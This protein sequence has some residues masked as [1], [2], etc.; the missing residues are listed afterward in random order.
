MHRRNMLWGTF[1]ALGAVIA[2]A[3]AQATS[4]TNAGGRLKVIH[5]LSGLDQVAFVLGNIQN[6]LDGVGGP[7]RVTIALVVH[8][9]AFGIFHASGAM[10]KVGRVVDHSPGPA[11]RFGPPS[12]ASSSPPAATP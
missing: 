4:E 6:H 3:S 5:H 2:A 1:S 10:P 7:D 12:P 11:S 8:G 9:P